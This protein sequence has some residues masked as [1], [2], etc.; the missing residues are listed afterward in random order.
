MGKLD[1]TVVSTPYKLVLVYGSAIGS[2][3]S[4]LLCWVI[5]CHLGKNFVVMF[6]CKNKSSSSQSQRKGNQ[7]TY[8]LV[9]AYILCAATASVLFSTLRSNFF[10]F[11]AADAFDTAQ[12]QWG[13]FLFYFFFFLSFCILF[14]V[15]VHKI[16]FIFRYALYIFLV[17]D[18]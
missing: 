18:P 13:Y 2:L 10:T 9:M 7:C 11:I 17:F 12:C 5:L 8:I 16:W 14:T 15:F 3:I 6:Y 1:I 4:V